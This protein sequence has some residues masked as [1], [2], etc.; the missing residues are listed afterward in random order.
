MQEVL[1][2]IFANS[3]S[4]HFYAQVEKCG[5]AQK[6]VLHDFI[7]IYARRVNNRI[8]KIAKHCSKDQNK[9]MHICF[10]WVSGEDL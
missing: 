9:K 4:S 1:M 5:F 7:Q 2:N 3:S 8:N 10:G 6:T